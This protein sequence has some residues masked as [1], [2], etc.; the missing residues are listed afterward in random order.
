MG[1]VLRK[2]LWRNFKENCISY[3]ALGAL[4]IL[5][6]YMVVSLVAAAETIITQVAR[7]AEENLVE[8][9]EFT[10]FVPLTEAQEEKLSETGIVLERKF[11]LDYEMADG[12]TLRVFA[13]REEINQVEL[14]EGKMAE[15]AGEAVLE[16]R[17]CEEHG[18]KAGN[19]IEIGGT[20]FLVTGI[21]TAPDYDAPKKEISDSA[22]DS[23]QFGIAFVTPESYAALK[24]AG[25]AVKS[26]EY[27]YAYRFKDTAGE[28]PEHREIKEI[29]KE[30]K[31][32]PEQI[33]DEYFKEYWEETGGKKEE[34]EDGIEELL[35]GA[36]KLEEGLGELSGS[37]ET[38]KAALRQYAPMLEETVTEYT[39]G[40]EMAEK[41]A[42]ELYSGVKELKGG[43]EEFLDAFDTD[44]SNL[45]SFLPAEDNTRI[46]ASA[47]DQVINKYAGLAAGV[48]V[49]ILLTYVISV[50][51]VHSIER[52]SSVIGA[53][54]ALGVKRKDLLRHYLILPA[55]V[56]VAAS[57]IGTAAGFSPAGVRVQ[58]GDNFRYFS[59]PEL[60]TVYPP[61]LLVYSILM[62]IAVALLVNFFVIRR[63][64]SL[65]VLEMLR[66]EPKHSK[67]NHINLGKL[68]FLRRFQIRQMLREMRTGFTVVFGMFI[69]ML[70]LMLAINCYVMCTHINGETEADTKYEYMYTYKYPTK[71]PPEGGSACFAKTLKKEV[72]GYNLE[73][74]I[75]GLEKDNPYFSAE[76]VKGRNKLVLSSTMAQKYGLK[77]GDKVVLTDEEEEL[78]YAFTVED[79]APY[80]ASLYA[81]MDIDSMRE[82]FGE[83]E[84]YYNV[85]FSEKELDIPAGRLYAVVTKEDIVESSEVFVNMMMPMVTMLSII[86]AVMFAVVMYL[87]MKVMID[88]SAFHISLIKI[89]GFRTR[90]I[91]KLYLDGNFYMVALGAAVCIPLAKMV[92]D[93]MYPY[94]VSNI[95]CSMNLTFSWQLYLGIF[96]GVLALYFVINRVLLCRLKGIMPAEV[97]KNRE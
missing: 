83:E 71:T 82:L 49:M 68:G 87:M 65:P 86:A 29:L 81:F 61:Y 34:L 64:L 48:I 10:V 42:G 63:K 19:T 89:F 16:K 24:A 75:L 15:A 46:G 58:M 94:L 91:K 76:T 67:I 13:N 80:A 55:V 30:F 66:N 21:G 85:V 50:F 11:Y 33:E 54:Y 77:T 88:R 32:S 57:L 53:L 25:T 27:V 43:S 59:N 23:L 6:M 39:D 31:V 18:L 62:P 84:D 22:V 4:I 92:M 52:E 72:L 8:D 51:V 73:V 79:I 1:K 3:L 14:D 2:R 17:Y 38:I 12:S 60:A 5:A 40:V 95:A 90:E 97:L 45:T 70:I 7:H 44:I 74:T 78:D 96:I 28:Q 41:G 26:E 69:S 93:R 20:S 35:E 47:D 9:G 36:E 37:H 56:T